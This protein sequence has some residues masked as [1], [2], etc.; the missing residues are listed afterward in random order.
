MSV[1]AG[2]GEPWDLRCTADAR[3]RRGAGILHQWAR[4]GR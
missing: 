4:S 2:G 3:L 1:V